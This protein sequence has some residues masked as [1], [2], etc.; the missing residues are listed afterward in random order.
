M[1]EAI[2]KQNEDFE[3]IKD[4]KSLNIS[5][6]AEIIFDLFNLEANSSNLLKKLYEEL[7]MDINSKDMYLKK[8][9]ME[10]IILDVVDDLIYRSRFSI[11]SSEINYQNFFKSVSIEFDYDKESILEKLVKY[12]QVMSELLD[13]ELFIIV[14]LD[15]FLSEEEIVEL[16][17]F[18]CYNEIKVLALQNT[19]TREVES[20][21]NL[22]ILDK[23]LCEI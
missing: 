21:E 5:K 10:R 2:N 8:I 19:I 22:R 12:I 13:K 1:I 20:C 18:L 23:D 14:N 15:S 7:E 11:K 9:D 6:S 3:L 17:K 4:L 16:K